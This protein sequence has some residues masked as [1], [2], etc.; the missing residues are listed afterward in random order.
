LSFCQ[1]VRICLRQKNAHLNHFFFKHLKAIPFYSK[2]KWCTD[3]V[4]PCKIISQKHGTTFCPYNT[5]FD[6]T[7]YKKRCKVDYMVPLQHIFWAVCQCL[8]NVS[9]VKFFHNFISDT[10][11]LW[12]K[13]FFS[14]DYFIS[15]VVAL[16]TSF[17]VIWPRSKFAP[18]MLWKNSATFFNE[19]SSFVPAYFFFF[20]QWRKALGLEFLSILWYLKMQLIPLPSIFPCFEEACVLG[21]VSTQRES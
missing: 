3:P 15:T 19:D 16:C 18:R 2:A 11:A 20:S 5:R 13:S 4:S 12:K 6:S 1:Q 21:Y 9:D 10:L 14:V 7:S 8:L 17:S